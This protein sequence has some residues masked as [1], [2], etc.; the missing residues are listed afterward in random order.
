MIEKDT[1]YECLNLQC[2]TIPD[3]VVRIG[4]K[5]FGACISLV[6]VSLPKSLALI[7]DGA[8]SACRSLTSARFPGDAPQL[9]SSVFVDNADGFS[10]Y[11]FENASGFGGA[12]W[13]E[14]GPFVLPKP[15]DPA[16]L[17]YDSI[18]AGEI[19]ITGFPEDESGFLTIPATIDGKRVEVIG[20]RAFQ[21]CRLLNGVRFPD[22]VFQIE[23]EAFDGC[24]GLKRAE[25]TGRA[26][27][28]GHD[29]FSGTSSDF[30]IH[31]Q[32]TEGGFETPVWEGYAAVAAAD[33]DL[34]RFREIEPGAVR[35]TGY[36]NFEIGSMS[37]PA[38]IGGKQVRE[39]A[40]NAFRD[41]RFLVSV[42]IPG[43][44]TLIDHNAFEGCTALKEISL[45]GTLRSI[46]HR[47]FYGCSRLA[48]VRIPER[49]SFISDSAFEECSSLERVL[50]LGEKAPELG[51]TVFTGVADGF[52]VYFYDSANGF[53]QPFW[54]GYPAAKVADPKRFD[55][56]ELGNGKV[57]ITGYPGHQVAGLSVPSYIDGDAVTE[58]G[59]GAFEDFSSLVYVEIPDG[60]SEI[61]RSAFQNCPSLSS[62]RL[63]VGL[64]GIGD[65]ALSG[66]P[67]L[68]SVTF[69]AGVESI[70]SR[71]FANCTDLEEASFT[72]DAPDLGADVFLEAGENF[73]VTYYEGA[74]GFQ[75][76]V[77]R[78][79][80][81][82]LRGDPALLEYF[83]TG[84]N[85]IA[86]FHYPNPDIGSIT[87][88]SVINGLTVTGIAG[89]AFRDF[90]LVSVKL[91]DGV[92]IIEDDAFYG[93]E[94]LTSVNFPSGLEYIGRQA[95]HR[96]G[97]I[98]VN[99]PDGIT[100]IERGT[101]SRCEDLVEVSLPPSVEFIEPEA[102]LGCPSLKKISFSEG[103]REISFFAFAHCGNL[104]GVTF[105]Q[106]IRRIEHAAFLDCRKLIGAT[107]L[108]DA[109]MM[110][111]ESFRDCDPLFA[112]YYP[113]GAGGFSTRYPEDPQAF[114]IGDIDAFTYERSENGWAVTGYSG[115]GA[116]V[117]I[118]GMVGDLP[119]V[120]I[121]DTAFSDRGDVRRV[122]IP[123]GVSS[124]GSG[125]F[126]DCPDMER[127]TFRGDEPSV[128]GGQLAGLSGSINFVTY[129][130]RDGFGNGNWQ[131]LPVFKYDPFEFGYS[132]NSITGYSG[133]ESAIVIPEH[134]P[135]GNSINRI[136]QGA[137]GG[138]PGL[139]G[140]LLSDGVVE[141]EPEAFAGC[142]DLDNVILSEG[143][144]SIGSRAFFDCRKL[145]TISIPASVTGIGEA[146]FSACPRLE[147]LDVADANETFGSDGGVLFSKDRTVLKSYPGGKT[148]D[149]TIP[150]SVS[151]V[152]AYSF[153][154]AE[155]LGV[156]TIPA[157]VNEI[158][159]EAFG[160]CP[161]FRG[162]FYLGIAPLM[163]D[164]V[165]DNSGSGVTVFYLEG[166][167]GFTQ[168]DWM[169]YPSS[170]IAAAAV[171]K[172]SWLVSN[173]LSHDSDTQEDLN[174]DGVPLV[175]AYALNLDPNENLA[176]KMPAAEISESSVS[177]EYYA[178]APGIQYRVEASKDLKTW[179]T[180]GI[181]LSG[182]DENMKRTAS[183]VRDGNTC[184]VRLVVSE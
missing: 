72:G 118:P 64:T 87:I 84:A 140:I 98:S 39:I 52:S 174:G 93:C 160:N 29:V 20:R 117:L 55:H 54:Q 143:L 164:R 96:T 4:R 121:R 158:G 173:R 74:F 145:E 178:A 109:P 85:E 154:G 97:L 108:G 157:G 122:S 82:L 135:S 177:L 45:P 19:R 2:I 78:G 23:S 103:L 165:F 90:N 159:R 12:P 86:I 110:D 184:F 50:F 176:G 42:E 63:P 58:I 13:E 1:F 148:G 8:F 113:E 124:I 22:G 136:G 33:P 27:G 71:A 163:G 9:G 137:F 41:F 153:H 75:S 21:G 155:N 123:P 168:P 151:L 107:F 25:F 59:S 126:E 172:V 60:V 112:V 92:T 138:T 66:C 79:Y 116:H 40:S 16:L 88:P 26:P 127:I 44:V 130:G 139:R 17:E 35:I 15:A 183:V 36:P 76:P 28:L 3:G 144:V 69:P 48:S 83:Q 146:A 95:F 14:Y 120:E 181:V 128:D 131:G 67:A 104:V 5:A 111:L 61:H 80:P 150:A 37:I 169:G 89:G 99:L 133:S 152:E 70:G 18:S 102:F 182:F 57:R 166:A 162:A 49:V 77:W 170:A 38:T 53:G 11:H 119:V 115:E 175:M 46:K 141:I 180:E 179:T 156:V 94:G 125:V 114:P 171:P 10:V 106:S 56:E 34:F 51:S 81:A 100:G 6:E 132:G 129:T 32:E 43:G 31:F 7:E 134:A 62:I 147:K 65:Q 167:S 73:V 161:S 101:F 68:A 105:P 47:V 24:T 149:Y 30:I 142:R 91:P